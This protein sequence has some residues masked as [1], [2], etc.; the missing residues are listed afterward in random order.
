[1]GQE[2]TSLT[3]YISKSKIIGWDYV[4]YVD[5][6]PI[7]KDRK[8]FVNYKTETPAD[9]LRLSY[10]FL[11]DTVIGLKQFVGEVIKSPVSFI[12]TEFFENIFIE[13][14]IPFYKFD[15]LKAAIEDWRNGV[16]ALAYRHRVDGKQGILATTQNL[17][18]EVPI[19]GSILDQWYKKE[20]SS[21]DRLFL[22]RGINGGDNSAQN[23]ALWVH[24]LTSKKEMDAFHVKAIPYR[25]G[26]VSDVVWSLL[27]ISHGFAYDMA[28]EI[29][30][31]NNVNPGDSIFLSGHSGGVQRIVSSARILNDDG[32][33][34]EKMYGISGPAL[35]YAP[36][37]KIEVELNGKILQDPTSDVSRLLNYL[38]FNLLTN[39]KWKYKKEVDKSHK[40][41]TPGFVDGRTRLKYDGFLDDSLN[42]FFK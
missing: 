6:D 20:S 15:G 35:G 25:Y 17:L 1:M 12:E 13:N 39:V 19:I 3:F 34:I 38:T 9:Y 28:S 32:I 5:Y 8:M 24:F 36:C 7:E 29:V 33:N 22:S 31:S 10:T 40:H 14:K 4:R 23:M 30:L 37:S 21:V 16:T 18:G 27:N 41:R 2:D 42:D 26:S 11:I